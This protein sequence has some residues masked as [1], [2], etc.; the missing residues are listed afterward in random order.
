M[1]EALPSSP[2][3]SAPKRKIRWVT[4]RI[5]DVLLLFVLLIGCVFRYIGIQWGD[6]Q[7]LHPDERF[8]IWVGTDIMPIGAPAETLGPPPNVINNPWRANFPSAYPDCKSWGGYFDASC[9][10]LNPNNRGHSFYVYGT[11]PMF[12]T[13]YI[14]EW[15]YGHSG[16]NEMTVVGR[17][18]SAFVDLLSVVLVYAIGSRAF[19]KAVGLLAAAFAA[20]T[21][22]NIQ[23]SHF[24]TMDTF[25]S[26]FTLLAVYFAVRISLVERGARNVTAD[27]VDSAVQG[28]AEGDEAE[29]SE[30]SSSR[31]LA[32]FKHP[33]FALSIGFG[34][35]LG[36]AVA[37]KLSAAPV[38]F[39]L[40]VAFGVVVLRKPAQ[41]RPRWLINAMIY[42]G[43]AAFISVLVFRIFQP[44]AFLGPGFLGVRPNPQWVSNIKEQRAQA[45]GDIDFPPSLQWA[46]RPIWF[47]A[48][49]MAEWGSGEPAGDPGSLWVLMGCL[50]DAQ[51]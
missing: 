19:N 26:F 48:Q 3:Q 42:L 43:M 31:L 40:P 6:F 1:T 27:D 22:L 47:S 11:L 13:R 24:F 36:C 51:R 29:P 39:V 14:V 9:S 35:A 4:P 5:Y 18:L 2:P 16:F 15:V 34:I 33:Y 28:L 45:A 30:T 38:A 10:P 41:E 44:Y 12:L 23:Q 7:Y 17:I 20:F 25:F 32:L 49:N 8:L 46:R 37:S 21:V 50:A